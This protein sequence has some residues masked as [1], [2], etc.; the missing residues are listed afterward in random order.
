V[1]LAERMLER[2]EVRGAR[3]FLEGDGGE[4]DG[5]GLAGRA[6]GVA[7]A[8]RR[9]GVEPGARVALCLPK[10]R[11]LVTAHVGVLAAG[12]VATPLNPA[13]PD[14]ALSSLIRRAEPT[15]GIADAAFCV[16]ARLLAPDLPWWCAGA[17]VPDGCSAL[18]DAQ[19]SIAAVPR[20]DDDPALL[21]FTSGTTGSPKGVPLS[22]GNLRS[23]LAALQRVWDWSREDRLLHVLPVFH[24]HGLG[25]ALYGS[26]LAGSSV[27][28]HERFEPERVL[29]EAGPAQISLLMA[30]PT[31]L[32]RLL[33]ASQRR[34]DARL[35]GLRAVIS[36]SAP[37][38]PALFERFCERFGLEPVER[39]GMSETLMNASN[40]VHGVRKPGSVGP[41]V[42]GV[43]IRLRDPVEGRGEVEVR[44][45]NVF[46]GYWNDADATAAA[47]DGEWFR[48]GDLGC[49]DEDGFLQLVGRAKE[50]IVTG[51]YNVSPLAVERALE[52]CT[53]VAE[54]AVAGVPDADLGERIAA[55][56]VPKAGVA[57]DDLE[58]RLRARAVAQLPRYAW[59]REYRSCES[60]PRNALGKVERARL[61]DRQVLRD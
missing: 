61:G 36:G 52:E 5:V 22:H 41:P 46:R 12:A 56:V 34:P 57:Y 33:E 15:L 1:N 2:L 31:M 19:G 7:E 23:N 58:A 42:P 59:P 45:P 20:R 17:P 47:F 11:A 16:R 25:V 49:F 10:G 51:G 18:T 43:E 9:A 50:I 54:L 38:A 8:L 55:F 13:Y 24:L 48:T 53:G 14:P 26:L 29:V 27:V 39:Y 60:L 32:H 44:G 37:L 40:P 30:V 3:P 6:R 21:V 28:L 4:H 35:A